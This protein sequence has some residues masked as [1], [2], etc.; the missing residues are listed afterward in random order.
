MTSSV[1]AI[2]NRSGREIA[3]W[4]AIGGPR[5][6]PGWIRGS[7]GSADA[8]RHWSPETGIHAVE[9]TKGTRRL[10]TVVLADASAMSAEAFEAATR[11]AYR[12]LLSDVPHG[13]LLRAWN[14]IPRINDPA[15]RIGGAAIGSEV[16]ERPGDRYMVFNAGR[17]KAF[18][19]VYGTPDWFPVASGV[20]HAGDDLVLH[21]LHED[22]DPRPVDNP[23]QVLPVDYSARFGDLPPAFT[24]AAKVRGVEGASILV[25]GTASV[26]GEDS[27]HS[28]SF[29]RQLEETLD[30]LEAVVAS[31]E[32]DTIPADLEDWLIYLPEP[33][34][35]GRVRDAIRRRWPDHRMTLEFRAQR[36]CRPELLVE[37]E[38]AGI[39]PEPTS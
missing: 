2:E 39:A 21:L 8:D 27:L 18:H 35:A 10:R 34:F 22:G 9:R 31:C 20:G 16:N 36:L 3:D 7:V 12:I 1:S 19:D 5:D 26:V 13:H 38:C 23:R 4:V 29:E 14:F 11:Q 25:S 17:F 28:D 15:D 33:A 24:R 30:N 37:I 32:V 6:L